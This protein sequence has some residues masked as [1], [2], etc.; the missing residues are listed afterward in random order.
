VYSMLYMIGMENKQEWFEKVKSIPAME[1]GK[2]CRMR[3]GNKVYY[4]HQ[5]WVNG[6]NQVRYVQA[7]DVPALREA[8]RGYKKFLLLVEEYA[9]AAIRETR[10]AKKRRK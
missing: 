3:R 7:E 10:K 8:I 6:R 2:L 9:D 5:A 1:R 4:N